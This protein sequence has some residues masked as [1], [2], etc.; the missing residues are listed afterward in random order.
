MYS[1]YVIGVFSSYTEPVFS[2]L[3]P[4]ADM[5]PSIL[6]RAVK[7]KVG[8]SKVIQAFKDTYDYVISMYSRVLEFPIFAFNCSCIFAAFVVDFYQSLISK[9]TT[10]T[11]AGWLGTRLTSHKSSTATQLLT[12]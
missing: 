4:S 3:Q 11:A 8:N 2:V 7:D 6:S 12:S 5:F 1:S 9:V 10:D